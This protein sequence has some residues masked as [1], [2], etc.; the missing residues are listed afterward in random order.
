MPN[1]STQE[2]D[3]DIEKAQQDID[4]QGK[5]QPDEKKVSDYVMPSFYDTGEPKQKKG[6]VEQLEY[7]NFLGTS[8]TDI[9]NKISQPELEDFSQ[10]L[11]Q[12]FSRLRQTESPQE[13]TEENP[14]ETESASDETLDFMFSKYEKNAQ[15]QGELDR[16]KYDAELEAKTIVDTARQ[17]AQQLCDDARETAYAQGFSQGLE[18]GSKKGYEQ[19]YAD[20]QNKVDEECA[21]MLSQLQQEIEDVQAQRENIFR[22]QIADMRDLSIT[23]AEKIIN[24]SLKS[25]NEIVEKMIA[26]ATEKMKNV[27][28]AKLYVSQ[29]DFDVTVSADIK[30]LNA[31]KKITDNVKIEIMENKPS[32]TCII[33]LPDQII[34]ASVDAQINQVKNILGKL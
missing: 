27:Q 28:W 25:S 23:I 17:E 11:D 19:A 32:G 16:L 8:K 30:I 31:V 33:E 21:Q 20:T 22:A 26:A 13:S 18:E 29:K 3:I 34:D 12:L 2:Q 10:S 9:E 7:D 24:V 6:D 1:L 4:A 15:H 14:Q 5:S